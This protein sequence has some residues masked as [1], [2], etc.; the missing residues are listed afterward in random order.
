MK[1]TN[2]TRRA[3]LALIL[4]ACVLSLVFTAAS[5]ASPVSTKKARLKAVQAKLDTVYTQV[6][7]AV[8]KY[9]Q[10]TSQLDNVELKIKENQRLLDVAEHN[11]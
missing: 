7:M 11:L 8:E 6:E 5:P 4:G 1:R 10:A 9:N 2:G 3:A